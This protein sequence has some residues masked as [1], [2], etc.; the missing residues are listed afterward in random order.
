[1]AKILLIFDQ[2]NKR[3]QTMG[4]L[5]DWE[6]QEF[7]SLLKSASIQRSD[8]SV[9]HLM[10]EGTIAGMYEQELLQHIALMKPNIVLPVGKNALR[11]LCGVDS[12]KKYVGSLL[13]STLL[14]GLKCMALYPPETLRKQYVTRY[15]NSIALTKVRTEMLTSELSVPTPT[16]L[17]NPSMDVIEHY[18]LEAMSATE[19]AFDIETALNCIDCFSLATSVDEG[20]SIPLYK[21]N[22]ACWTVREETRIFDLLVAVLENE[23]IAKV[24]QNGMYDMTFLYER[25]GIMVYNYEDTMIAQALLYPEFP[26]DLGFLGI[27]HTRFPYHKDIA[28]DRFKTGN[29]PDMDFWKYSALDSIVTLAAWYE[30]KQKIKRERMWD[31]YYAQK[32]LCHLLMAMQYRG[33]EIDTEKMKLV[34]AIA[35]QDLEHLEN[36]FNTLA[37][38]HSKVDSGKLNLN[39]SQQMSKYFYSDR[40]PR[41]YGK[42]NVLSCDADHMKRIAKYDIPEASI[43]MQYKKLKKMDST[44]FNASLEGN[45]LRCAYKP[46]GTKTGRLSSTKNIWGFGSNKQ[47]QPK[48]M[49]HFMRVRSGYVMYSVD[50]AGAEN[51]IVANVGPVPAMKLA[52]DNG[53]D[54]H[55]LTASFLYG[56]KVEDVSREPRS[57]GLIG[58]EKSQRD[59]GK[60]FN[61]SGNYGISCA[62]LAEKLEVLPEVL[63]PVYDR[64]HNVYPEV[65]GCFQAGIEEALRQGR[66]LENC[67]GRRR[68]FF[69]AW[70]DILKPAYAFPAQS[71]IADIINRNGLLFMYNHPSFHHVVLTNQIHDS[72]EFEIPLSC[73]WEYH[74]TILGW[75]KESLEKPIA[76]RTTEFSIPA[77]FTMAVGYYSNDKALR[78]LEPLAL[79]AVYVELR[80]RPEGHIVL[81]LNDWTSCATEDELEGAQLDE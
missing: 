24:M 52:F 40:K 73:G 10:R 20:I 49:K 76:W 72:I 71:L 30:L 34:S 60:L 79:D 65:R 8:Y 39:S 46:V 38:Q 43:L 63:Q 19:I 32:E 23:A 66:C 78:S 45:L 47:N 50:L 62:K 48:S 22:K 14:P 68:R 56:C 6:G 41:P 55:S 57:A 12:V 36:E 77:E 51:R 61:H 37:T 54:V 13:D 5:A 58:S 29:S 16:L 80:E 70:K 25:Y 3:E 9:Y 18:L 81:D 4:S 59:I 15:L 28:K 21:S 26:K 1:M 35:K 11:V 31:T 17:L 75:L 64:Y 7:L 42:P 2:L 27:Q 33:V 69:G 53:I 74:S 44:Y 67:F